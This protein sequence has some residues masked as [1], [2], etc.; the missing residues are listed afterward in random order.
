MH[1]MV[2]GDYDKAKKVQHSRSLLRST[3]SIK[4]TGKAMVQTPVA[5]DVGL[6]HIAL[7][8]SN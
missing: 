2:D 4:G 5:S 1:V 8:L 6:G 7:D 3:L